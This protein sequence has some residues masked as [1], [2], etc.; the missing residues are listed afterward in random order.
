[1]RQA[2]EAVPIAI[3]IMR[4]I[5]YTKRMIIKNDRK[6]YAS[7]LTDS[8]WAEIKKLF[9]KAGNKS[10]WE[11]RELVNAVLYLVENGY[12]WRNLPHDFPPHTTVYNF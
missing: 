11:K 12:K 10:K 6:S 9:P 3:Y 2:W 4:K 7:D 8:Q 5:W 1:M